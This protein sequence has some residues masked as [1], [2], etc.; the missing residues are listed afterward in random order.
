MSLHDFN[1]SFYHVNSGKI[2]E[3]QMAEYLSFS[4]KNN[5]LDI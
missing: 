3:F 1:S 2:N 5:Y 4:I